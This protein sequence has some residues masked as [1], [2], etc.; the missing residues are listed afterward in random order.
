M[1][2]TVCGGFALEQHL[3]STTAAQAKGFG[4]LFGPTPDRW[5]VRLQNPPKGYQNEA[6]EC[7]TLNPGHV[8]A[9]LS[10]PP[11]VRLVSE[12]LN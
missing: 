8:F 2:A 1:L 7:G 5:R 11:A 12:R 10:T 3:D 4:I 9:T 6:A